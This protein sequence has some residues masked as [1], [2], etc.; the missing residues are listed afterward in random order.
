MRLSTPAQGARNMGL[1][2]QLC[3]VLCHARLPAM[4]Q[5]SGAGEEEARGGRA[6]WF[7]VVR[8]GVVVVQQALQSTPIFSLQSHI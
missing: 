8:C 6:V 1:S 3:K 2:R 4:T 7:C 5:S